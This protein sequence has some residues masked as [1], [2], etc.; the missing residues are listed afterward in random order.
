MP[1][2]IGFVFIL[3][4]ML[5]W[6]TLVGT[7]VLI[8]IALATEWLLRAPSD[9]MARATRQRWQMADASER[10]YEALNAMGFAHRFRKRFAEISER[11]IAANER[12]G[13]IVSGPGR[14]RGSSG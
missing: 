5:G 4:P 10:N 14:C 2:Y 1:L 13:D 12:L 11:Q 7:V 9:A 8:G 3:H 6:V